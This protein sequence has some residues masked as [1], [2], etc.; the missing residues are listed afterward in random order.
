[1][2][3]GSR[4]ALLPA[5]GCGLATAAVWVIAF[6]T[7]VGARADATVLDDFARL[8]YAGA[9]P[10]ADFAVGLVNPLPFAAITLVLMLVALAR[11]RPRQAMAVPVA[12]LGAS[13]TTELLKPLAT[14]PRPATTPRF[15]PG[16]DGWP[17]GHMTAAM[18]V[19]LCLVLVAPARLRPSAAVVGGSFAAIQGYGVLVLGWHYPSDVVAA[20]AIAAGWLALSVAV[21]GALREEP[22]SGSLGVRPVAWPAALATLLA[23]AFVA[24]AVLT[25]PDRLVYYV[26]DD[27][28]LVAAAIALGLAA[29]GVVALAAAGL[30]LVQRGDRTSDRRP[31]PLRA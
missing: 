8:R 29:L 21:L 20:C 24:G 10:L 28:T 25:R 19:A 7:P 17:S 1:M 14:V 11:R 23:G 16:I 6:Q 26:R 2:P 12:A 22:D 31:P 13:L 15:A 5:A 30:T 18:A 3:R 9:W 27:T 4:A